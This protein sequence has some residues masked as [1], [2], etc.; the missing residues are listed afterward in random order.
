LALRHLILGNPTLPRARDFVSA[1]ARCG[2]P[3]P[4]VRAHADVIAH[5]ESL[6]DLPDEPC[7]VRIDAA[8][9]EPLVE[10]RLLALGYPAAAA[11]GAPAIEPGAL[12]RM[13][14]EHG[15][16][17]FPRQHH[18]GFLAYLERLAAV[19]AERPSWWPLT[20]PASIAEMFD[21][22]RT[23]ARFITDRIPAPEPLTGITDPEALRAAMD[24]RGWPR[25]F[26]KLAYASSASGLLVLRRNHG[27]ESAMTTLQEKGGAF[28]NARVVQR[29]D[30]RPAIDRA[31]AFLLAEGA[32]I[33]EGVP[34]ARLGGQFFDCRVIV[35]AGAA[36]FLIVRQSPH[37]ITNLQLGGRRGSPEALRAAAGDAAV[38][39]ACAAC[40]RA[41]RPFGAHHVGLDVLF[42]P[43]FAGHRLLEA[44]AFGDYFPG[45]VASGRTVFETEIHA[46][47]D[48]RQSVPRDVRQSGP[49]ER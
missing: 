46:A 8:G 7:A 14:F 4:W 48:V 16:V 24:A 45:L 34:K 22:R 41:A 12:A 29:L 9:K 19:L 44:N 42:E 23:S 10:R 25:V 39:A 38:A 43:R 35:I 37:L 6:L 1:L 40:E 47:H 20:P 30:D 36:S 26:V 13:P 27:D 2:A 17:L 21:K 28:F 3:D 32:Q 11:E 15:R 49:P 5:P 33:E 31:L 18:L